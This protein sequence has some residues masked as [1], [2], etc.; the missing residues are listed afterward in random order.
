MSA[1]V[2]RARLLPDIAVQQIDGAISDILFRPI[3]NVQ[4]D[5]VYAA[6]S[7]ATGRAFVKA[8][9]PAHQGAV[10]RAPEH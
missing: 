7:G 4:P 5:M 6:T 1:F 3:S 9:A 8:Y 2:S 10:V